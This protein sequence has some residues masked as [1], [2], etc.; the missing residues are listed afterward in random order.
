MLNENKAISRIMS[1]VRS[2]DQRL[3]QNSLLNYGSF[4]SESSEEETQ[5]ELLKEAKKHADEIV[6]K[7]QLD[8]LERKLR[9]HKKRLGL[10]PDRAITEA[11]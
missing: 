1:K 9:S 5:D 6:R 2:A 4:S 3:K 8:R 7:E 11:G 10:D